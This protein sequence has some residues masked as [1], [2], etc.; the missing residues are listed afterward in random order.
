MDTE[1]VVSEMFSVVLMSIFLT[2]TIVILFH[3][4]HVNK[5]GQ[6]PNDV[7]KESNNNNKD[8]TANIRNQRVS[9]HCDQV[10]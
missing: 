9:I 8:L 6:S 1:H 10:C 7:I 5:A 2:V 4:N 3:L